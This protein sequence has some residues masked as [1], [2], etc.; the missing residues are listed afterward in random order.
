MHTKYVSGG[1]VTIWHKIDIILGHLIFN[2]RND[3]VIGKRETHKRQWRREGKDSRRG[4]GAETSEEKGKQ[5]RFC[6]KNSGFT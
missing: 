1:F 4:G 2:N 6:S 5:E 3:L